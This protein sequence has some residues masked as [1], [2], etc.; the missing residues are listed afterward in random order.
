MKIVIFLF[1]LGNNKAKMSRIKL[2]YGEV[3]DKNRETAKLDLPRN[4]RT[5][6]YFQFLPYL[7]DGE[8]PNFETFISNVINNTTIHKTFEIIYLQLEI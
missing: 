4:Y 2:P 5:T 1:L 6:E 8:K 7:N 3:I